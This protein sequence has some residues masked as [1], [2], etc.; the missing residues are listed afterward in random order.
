M[1]ST[2]LG[3]QQHYPGQTANPGAPVGAPVAPPAYNSYQKPPP[4]DPTYS[5][6]QG[7]QLYKISALVVPAIIAVAQA[8][9]FACP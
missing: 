2:H 9:V 8:P 3:P 7:E 4:G 5:V 1:P 6:Q